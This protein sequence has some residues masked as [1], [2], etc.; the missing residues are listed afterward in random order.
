MAKKIINSYDHNDPIDRDIVQE[1]RDKE[2]G[3][4]EEQEIEGQGAGKTRSF[5][6]MSGIQEL[7]VEFYAELVKKKQ[8]EN[9]KEKTDKKDQQEQKEKE[10]REFNK[11]ESWDKESVEK[12]AEED[13][14]VKPVPAFIK[15]TLK[16]Y[17]QGKETD[18]REYIFAP[19]YDQQAILLKGI[20]P[21]EDPKK[22]QAKGSQGKAPPQMPGAN[23]PPV[24]GRPGQAGSRNMPPPRTPGRPGLRGSIAGGMQR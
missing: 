23:R 6:V 7:K 11:V 4:F 13:K 17:T 12:L 3:I 8:K 20:K 19:L 16:L 18:E 22:Q 10:P 24:S 5:K 14:A 1:Q 2:L 9:E 15:V 21:L